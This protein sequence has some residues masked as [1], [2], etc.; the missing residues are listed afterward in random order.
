MKIKISTL[1]FLFTLLISSFSKA[2]NPELLVVK[3]GAPLKIV[4]QSSTGSFSF[5]FEAKEGE[6]L[7]LKIKSL[8]G[9]SELITV[10]DPN[11]KDITSPCFE[12]NKEGCDLVSSSWVKTL[13]TTGLYTLLLDLMEPSS[14]KIELVLSK[15]NASALIKDASATCNDPWL[16]IDKKNYP[17][18]LDLEKC[19][20][21]KNSNESECLLQSI[22]GW[23]K[24]LN[25]FYQALSLHRGN[26]SE[27]KNSQQEWIKHRDLEFKYFE[28]LVKDS[29][30]SMY[31]VLVLK[32]KQ[33]LVRDRVLELRN[34]LIFLCTEI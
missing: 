20:D 32:W 17:L 23:D 9:P 21:Q 13:S 24:Q 12:N 34:L 33:N 3:P 5:Q 7:D 27:L 1:F 10:K 25:I 4:R 16:D 18:D 22:Q 8:Q 28:S 26:F 19:L 11:G 2:Q 29:E 14:V 15:T 6:T 31:P 30:G